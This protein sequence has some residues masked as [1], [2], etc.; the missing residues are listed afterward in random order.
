MKEDDAPTQYKND[1]N[2]I[3]QRKDQTERIKLRL[4]CRIS[5]HD[6]D[7]MIHKRILKIKAVGGNER[8]W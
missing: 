7:N 5:I 3:W 6:V 1:S 2:S 4:D 8:L